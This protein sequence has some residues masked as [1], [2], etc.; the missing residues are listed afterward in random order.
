M[1]SGDGYNWREQ[2][3]EP[4]REEYGEKPVTVTRAA[5]NE[6]VGSDKI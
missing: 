3:S 6:G 1:H 2:E 5:S 4:W